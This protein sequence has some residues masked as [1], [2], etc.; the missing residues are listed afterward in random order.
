[1]SHARNYKC[2]YKMSQGY[3]NTGEKESDKSRQRFE[4]AMLLTLK[5]EERVMHQEIQL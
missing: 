3:L 5:T 2:S 4:D 1:M